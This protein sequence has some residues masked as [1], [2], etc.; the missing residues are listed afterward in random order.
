MTNILSTRGANNHVTVRAKTAAQIAD[1]QHQVAHIYL[2][3]R[4]Y[5]SHELHPE[6]KW[7][8][9]GKVVKLPKGSIWSSFELVFFFS[10]YS[11]NLHIFANEPYFCL[12]SF[13][14]LS[15]RNSNARCVTIQTLGFS[16]NLT[17][18]KYKILIQFQSLWCNR[19]Q[20]ERNQKK[21]FNRARSLSDPLSDEKN[22]SCVNEQFTQAERQQEE[23]RKNQLAGTIDNY[24]KIKATSQGVEME[25]SAGPM[26][27]TTCSIR[28]HLIAA[29]ELPPRPIEMSF[30][31]ELTLVLG[32]RQRLF[33]SP[34]L[35]GGRFLWRVSN[36]CNVFLN[37]IQDQSFL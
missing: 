12:R 35:F 10:L 2:T 1:E 25:V 11:F 3:N 7:D 22:N 24:Y 31:D 27:S 4:K 32:Q 26:G 21:R 8:N 14:K 33:L 30:G 6:L 16:P 9:S 37:I 19:Y 18:R 17:L 29:L 34:S 23:L 15:T 13:V 36:S 28:R 5:T 20:A